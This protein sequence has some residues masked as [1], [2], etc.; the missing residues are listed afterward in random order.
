MAGGGCAVPAVSAVR[1]RLENHGN[2]GEG[3]VLQTKEVDRPLWL[4]Q[5]PQFNGCS[6][7]L[8]FVATWVSWGFLL[9]LQKCL[10]KTC[11]VCFAGDPR[12]AVRFPENTHK[13]NCI[14]K[15]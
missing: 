13:S 3:E 11:S 15:E 1:A 10:K 4:L 2:H 12:G 5:R 8:L 14:L 6:A 7:V 9:Q